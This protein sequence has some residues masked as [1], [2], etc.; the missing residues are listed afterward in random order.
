[1][2]L[3]IEDKF[4][5]DFYFSFSSAIRT[6]GVVVGKSFHSEGILYSVY[7]PFFKGEG[8]HSGFCGEHK[9]FTD[10]VRNNTPSKYNN[11]YNVLDVN[12]QNI[13][14]LSPRQLELF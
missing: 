13:D 3:K 6:K 1:M 14:L 4:I 9:I 5:A 2:E 7:F 12:I 10:K 11:C 8:F